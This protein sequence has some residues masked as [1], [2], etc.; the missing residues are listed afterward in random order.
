LDTYHSHVD[1]TPVLQEARGAEGHGYTEYEH[2]DDVELTLDAVVDVLFQACG[3]MEGSIMPG[4]KVQPET[5]R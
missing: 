4:K 1:I 3:A 2:H 5:V